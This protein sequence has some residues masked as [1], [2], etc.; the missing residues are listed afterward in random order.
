MIDLVFWLPVLAG[1]LVAG[2]STGLLGA[3]I[4]GMRIP[5]IG[6]VV[7]HAA[8]AGAIAGSLFGLQGSELLLP[9]LASAV[10]F[11]MIL[12]LGPWQSKTR[13]SNTIMGVLLSLTMGLAFLGIGLFERF[14]RSDSEALSMLW[15][16]L[17]FCCWEDVTIMAIAA[18][19]AIT[20]IWISRNQLQ[21]IMFSRELALASG[22]NVPLIWTGF[23]IIAC[24]ILTVNLQIVGGLMIYSLLTNPAAAAFMITK[25][26]LKCT[27]LSGV[28]GILSA[29]GGFLAAL[30]FNIP[31]GAAIVLLS[32]MLLVV[33][34]VYCKI[35][36]S[37]KA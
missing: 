8:M 13:D 22:V 9:S 35:R 32:A 33:A 7:S 31:T 19:A 11:A 30:Y 17:T 12:G 37:K 34:A 2:L 14:G 21:A 25:G 23:L 20:F 6:I 24:V 5:F 36:D 16:S 28:F 3:H 4:V 29:V 26:Y 10:I 27:I 15:G 18:I 1:G